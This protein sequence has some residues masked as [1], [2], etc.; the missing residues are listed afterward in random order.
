MKISLTRTE[1]RLLYGV[2]QAKTQQKLVF[3]GWNVRLPIGIL[4]L[5]KIN[6]LVAK[7]VSGYWYRR[8][9][10]QH[11]VVSTYEVTDCEDPRANLINK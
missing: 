8:V 11:A 1:R 10:G 2:S 4:R 3:Q 6:K 5:P 7:I 9:T